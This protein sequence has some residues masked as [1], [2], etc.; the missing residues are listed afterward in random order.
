MVLGEPELDFDC[1]GAERGH[2]GMLA[3]LLTDTPLVGLAER[4]RRSP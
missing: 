3:G 2:G 1:T 4:M